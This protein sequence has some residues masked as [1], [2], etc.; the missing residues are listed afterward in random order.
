MTKYL[1][2][3]CG[4]MGLMLAGSGL[5]IKS[6]KSDLALQIANAQ[7]FEEA[8]NQCEKQREKANEISKKHQGRL[9]DLNRK[10]RDYRVRDANAVCVNIDEATRRHNDATNGTIVLEKNGLRSEWLIEYAGEAERTRLQLIGCQEFI[11]SLE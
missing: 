7:A 3:A 4:V 1:L 9:A 6:L 8:N 11:Q 2:I 10:L 5:W